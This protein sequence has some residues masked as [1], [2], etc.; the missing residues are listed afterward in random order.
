MTPARIRAVHVLALATKGL[1]EDTYRL[2]L[3]A[4]CV[5]S[6]KQFTRAQYTLF[7]RELGKLPDA[8]PPRK[9]A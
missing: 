2:R 3:G 6:C 9:L 4:A 8:A 5:A 1:S 7:M